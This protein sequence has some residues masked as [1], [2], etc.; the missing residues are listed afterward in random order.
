MNTC[1]GC[2]YAS[3]PVCRTVCGAFGG[4]ICGLLGTSLVGAV[5][6][7][8]FVKAVCW[9]AEKASGCGDDLAATICKS[10]G[11]GVCGPNEDGDIIDA[12]I[13]YI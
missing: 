1:S 11:I 10:S 12:D 3:K 13:P 8:T 9:V 5:G 2:Y 7:V 4:F 6:C